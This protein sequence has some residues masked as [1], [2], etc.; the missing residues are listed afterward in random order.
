VKKIKITERQMNVLRS[1][2]LNESTDHTIV[3]KRLVDD[4]DKNYEPIVG[5]YRK[6]GEYYEKPIIRIKA[7]DD[8]IS[9]KDLFQYLKYKNKTIGDAFLKQ[10]VT[11]WVNGDINDYTL[12]KNV[13]MS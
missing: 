9:P 4:L 8:K 7:D 5:T 11:D 2:E 13:S 3:V 10:V 6:G 1:F 12:T